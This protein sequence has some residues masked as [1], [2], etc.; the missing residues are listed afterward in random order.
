[1]LFQVLDDKGECAGYYTDGRL[2]YEE[3]PDDLTGTW[4][5]SSHLGDRNVNYA[6]LYC[7]GQNLSEVCPEIQKDNWKRVT[8][9]LRAYLRSFDT[10]KVSLDALCFFQ[11]VPKR[12]L[13]EF[14]DAKNAISKHVLENY[15][16]PENY[17]FLVELSKVIAD[18]SQRRLNLDPD[19][20]KNKLATKRIR[21][22]WKKIKTHTRIQY[23]VFGTKTG[24]L[25]TKKGSF[26]ILTMDS[27]FRSVIKPH[28]DW[29]VE[30]D[31]NAA[32]LRVLLALSENEQPLEDIHEW[33]MR[34]IFKPGLSRDDAKKK[35]F[36]WLYNPKSLNRKAE[37]VYNR[38][39]VLGKYFNGERVKTIY[40]KEIVADDHYALNYIVQS[41]TSDLF[42]R[43][44]CE[45][46]KFLKD[47]KSHI[48]FCVHDSM[49]LDLAEEDK[50]VLPEIIKLFSDTELGTFKVNMSAGHNFG[51][52]QEVQI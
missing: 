11:L 4:D 34:N 21:D 40:G 16:Q 33:N 37:D 49:V 20:L 14:F 10:A 22:F 50:S 1:M 12:F 18:M 29:L 8:E 2:V 28:N 23:N 9:K 46:H 41:T 5:Y 27:A 26:P 45:V 30:L 36:A 39:L 17:E 35:I 51:E 31:F 25:T 19:V 38:S 7:G 24:R 15:P 32:E 48:S 13:L 3:L 6:R 42:L 47:R 44:L 43:R 52:M